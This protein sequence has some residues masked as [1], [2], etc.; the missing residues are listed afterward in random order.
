MARLSGPEFRRWQI[1]LKKKVSP[2]V[3]YI[4]G[5]CG[6]GVLATASSHK[7]NVSEQARVQA[8]M[9]SLPDE[10]KGKL[11]VALLRE[12]QDGEGSSTISL[13]Q[14][15]G[16]KLLEV[17]VG[18]LPDSPEVKQ[19]SLIEVQVIAGKA[20]LT[21]EQQESVVADLRCK[22]GRK[23]VESGLQKAIP[24][25]NRKYSE[26]FTVEEKEFRD[27]DNNILKKN[28]YF[29]HSPKEFFAMVDR[30]R[31]R[32][33]E[34]QI[35][36]IQGDTGQGFLKVSVSRIKKEEL[37]KTSY[38]REVGP[39]L[40]YEETEAEQSK[41][42][43]KRR[44]RQEGV[45]GGKEFHDWGVRKMLILA[46][47]RKIP[48]NAH[49]LQLIFAALKLCELHFKLTGDFSFFMPCF[50]L[51]KGCG[52]ANPCPL[53]DQERSKVGGGKA[54]W[55][56]G[57]VSL[58]SFQS[59][60]Q[61]HQGWVE[62]GRKSS[63]AQ[64]KKWKSVTGEVLVKGAGDTEDMLIMDKI[65]PGPLHLYLSANEVINFCEGS[66]WKEIKAVLEE[67]CGVQVH[68]YMGK[69]GNYEGPEL[70][71]IL[72]KLEILKDEMLNHPRNLYYD[73]LVAFRQVSESVFSTQL[74]PRWRDHLHTLRAALHT[75]T[76][77]QGMPLTPKLHVLVHHVEQ[78]IDRN[79]R[80]LGKEGEASGEALHH[81]FKLMLEGQGEVKVKESD[82]DIKV[83]FSTLLRFNAN[84]T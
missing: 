42:T 37:E 2:D 39:G 23:V 74:D 59:L 8:L 75:L 32:E 80:S 5:S 26:F 38:T 70:R 43:R 21:G 52:A 3:T 20:H 17:T 41:S 19:L 6:R 62:G 61:N 48:E 40:F 14:P 12:Q 71:K 55:V 60:C 31:G 65:I 4:C 58:R 29:C 25:H 1:G 69:A 57:E 77:S 79:G 36:L 27:K 7:C 13:P 33:G 83:I 72:R 9:M 54:R 45:S 11:T 66:D 63:A 46:I 28:L 68:E 16:G 18:R 15:Q 44:T 78:W 49:N 67:K 84:N 76:I 81:T 35:T 22:F 30:K 51:C 64:T 50:G 53:C 82:S 10:V 56:E 73:V 24:A 47:V 34:D